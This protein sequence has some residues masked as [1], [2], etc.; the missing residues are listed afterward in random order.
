MRRMLRVAPRL[1]VLGGC[2]VKAS[3]DSFRYR[4]HPSAYAGAKERRAQTRRRATS[5]RSARASRARAAVGR[6]P[7]SSRA[8]NGQGAASL[9]PRTASCSGTAS[10]SCG[11]P[12]DGRDSLSASLFRAVSFFVIC[13][14]GRPPAPNRRRPSG[15]PPRRAAPG[16]PCRLNNGGKKASQRGPRPRHSPLACVCLDRGVISARYVGSGKWGRAI[17][18]RRRGNDEAL[19]RCRDRLLEDGSA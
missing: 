16:G 17:S 19:Y 2:D 15:L 14:D 9:A 5:S 4:S 13:L 3:K 11:K 12:P 10:D 18:L 8:R 7:T 6:S 1:A